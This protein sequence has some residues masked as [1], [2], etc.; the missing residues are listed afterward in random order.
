MQNIFDVSTT[1][2]R[3]I[4]LLGKHS[5][6]CGDVKH[7]KRQGRRL[8]RIRRGNDRGDHGIEG[9]KLDRQG[10]VG[11]VGDLGLEIGKLRRCEAHGAGHGLAVEEAC[12][13]SVPLRHR[14]GIAR[15]DLDEI[16]KDIVVLD[17]QR[18]DA[19]FLGVA[20]LERGDH[21]TRLVAQGAHFVQL[22]MATIAQETAIP[23]QKRKVVGQHAGQF[24]GEV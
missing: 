3:V 8:D 7:G 9:G 21:A 19:G 1:G 15:C 10:P 18:S 6:A 11:G 2:R 13:G 14:P 23:L 12:L 22:A 5:K 4:L 24:G 17:L 20:L 16:S